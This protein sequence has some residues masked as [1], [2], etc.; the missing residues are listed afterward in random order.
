MVKSES[1]FIKNESPRHSLL[2]DDILSS[3]SL[4]KEQRDQ[5]IHSFK[6]ENC[7]ERLERQCERAYSQPCSVRSPFGSVEYDIPI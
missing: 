4:Q 6:S 1:L 3:R 7:K 2:K 5:F